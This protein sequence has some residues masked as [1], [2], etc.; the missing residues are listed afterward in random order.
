[1]LRRAGASRRRHRSGVAQRHA[2]VQPQGQTT[3][4]GRATKPTAAAPG[5][6]PRGRRGDPRVRAAWRGRGGCGGRRARGCGAG[7]YCHGSW[8]WPSAVRGAILAQFLENSAPTNWSPCPVS[9]PTQ[10][11][12]RRDRL[13]PLRAPTLDVQ[14]CVACTEWSAPVAAAH[15]RTDAAAGNTAG[16]TIQ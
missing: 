6:L 7:F 8:A 12:G 4:A 15:P 1:M 2:R 11:A 14:H 9:H 3:H 16:N 13:G 10:P 5:G